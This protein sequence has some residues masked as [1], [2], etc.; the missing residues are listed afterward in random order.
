MRRAGANE[1]ISPYDFGGRRM[2]LTALRPHVAEFL[3]EVVFDEGRGAEMDEVPVLPDS[4]LVNRTLGDINL[5]RQFGVTVIAL[6]HPDLP[7]FHEVT[8]FELNPGSDA[9]LHAGDVLIVVGTSEQLA[10]VHQALGA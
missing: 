1:V 4:S 5:R 8:G 10:R 6:Y 7:E 9:I 3:S 2:A